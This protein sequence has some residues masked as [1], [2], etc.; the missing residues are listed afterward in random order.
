MGTGKKRTV[1]I[2]ASDGES[3]INFRGPFIRYLV[4]QGNR[5]VCV[6]IEPP[7]EMREPIAALGAAYEQVAGSRV[8]IGVGDGLK[9]IRDYRRLFLRSSPDIC[10]F[11]MSKPTAFGSAAA[12][13]SRVKHYSVLVNG[14][15]NAFYRTGLKDLVVRCVMSAFYRFAARRADCVFFQ[16]RD[17]LAYFQSHRLLTKD[18]T[19][20]VGGSGV[21]MAYFAEQPLPREPVFLMVARLLWSKG[22]REYLEA[23]AILKREC[24]EAK[25]LLVG[26]MDRNDESLTEEELDRA[27]QKAE[28]EYCGHADDVR[29]YL[30]RCSVFVLP[31]YHEGLP[32]SVLEA[33][34]VGRAIVTTDVPGC[35]E[36][37]EDGKNGFIVPVKDGKALAEKMLLLAKDPALR[38]TMGEASRRICSER[39]EVGKVNDKMYTAMLAAME[40]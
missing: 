18:N 24:P 39:F 31:S 32:R 11:Y 28:L 26:G 25:C 8:G 23:A 14:M 3:L 20:L 16:N 33:M 22:V 17:D 30:A 19:V 9:M 21:D 15:E 36:T 29:P 13:L 38:E 2:A 35:R 7:E 10:F 34:S 6:S 40:K 1:V 4:A 5:V 12:A 37:V 27:L